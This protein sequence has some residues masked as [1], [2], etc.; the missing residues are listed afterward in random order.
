MVIS[1]ENSNSSGIGKYNIIIRDETNAQYHLAAIGSKVAVMMSPQHWSYSWNSIFHWTASRWFY[2]SQFQ[3]LYC[4]NNELCLSANPDAFSLTLA[5]CSSSSLYQTFIYNQAENELFW[6]DASTKGQHPIY[7]E[8][9]GGRTVKMVPYLPRKPFISR[10][11]V[12]KSI[13][14]HIRRFGDTLSGNA[15]NDRSRLLI[16]HSLRKALPNM[17][18]IEYRKYLE[19]IEALN[20]PEFDYILYEDNRYLIS[21]GYAVRLVNKEQMNA[22]NYKYYGLWHKNEKNHLIHFLSGKYLQAMPNYK[23]RNIKMLEN[24][25]SRYTYPRQ[26]LSTLNDTFYDLK[27]RPYCN[28]TGYI[29]TFDKQQMF[30]ANYDG[31]LMK[32]QKM[33]TMHDADLL[34]GF[35]DNGA[36]DQF[37]DIV[38]GGLF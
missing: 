22:M 38:P 17:S 31:K 29:V 34:L 30:I 7:L 20:E 12:I 4:F 11:L 25:L 18:D 16:L 6:V 10:N 14:D 28:Q 24:M 1:V 32:I 33:I 37:I 19:M 21:D 9:D 3:R 13:S 2:D 26:V 36:F 15:S 27:L 35:I 23:S 8:K 5:N